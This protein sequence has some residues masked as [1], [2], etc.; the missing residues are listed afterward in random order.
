[1]VPTT[2]DTSLMEP[3][4]E[5]RGHVTMSPSRKANRRVDRPPVIGVTANLEQD[6]DHS[7]AQYPLDRMDYVESIINAGGMPMILPPVVE[8]RMSEVLLEKMDGLLLSGGSDLDPGYYGEE[9][10]FEFGG[11]TPERD[12]FEMAL[13]RL[14]FRRGTPVFG[15]CRGLQML[16]VALGRTLYQ[17]LPSQFG[18]STRTHWQE[19]PK[20]QPAH[21]IEILHDSHLAKITGR[22]RS[23]VNSY[24]HQGIK[25]LADGLAV[26]ARSPDGV[27]EAVEYRNLA[28][29]W[30]IGVQWH[31]EMMREEGTER[32][33]VFE[34]H[35]SAAKR[36]SALRRTAA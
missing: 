16:N 18:K 13:L 6:V 29:R 24:H 12:T 9:P 14:A 34:A 1:M 30:L 21:E 26:S 15:I 10:V 8:T 32:R 2:T 17:D 27:I 4:Q 23:K 31:P 11:A 7:A 5:E 20:W 35:V 3:R 36:H 25:E 33:A 28:E 22:Q 19:T